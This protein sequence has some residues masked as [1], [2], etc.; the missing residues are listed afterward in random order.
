[1]LG[2][3]AADSGSAAIANRHAPT[4]C[5]SIRGDHI[6]AQLQG[7]RHFPPKAF[8]AVQGDLLTWLLPGAPEDYSPL[9]AC[10]P[11]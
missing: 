3:A 7:F 9:K 6:H 8:R 1:M 4:C 2:S 5:I 10:S 11:P